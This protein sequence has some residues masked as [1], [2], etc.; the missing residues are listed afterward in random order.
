MKDTFTSENRR[1]FHQRYHGCFAWYIP[2]HGD[3]HLVR[4][5]Q[6]NDK[7]VN[8]ITEDG[9]AYTA[10]IDQGVTWEFTQLERGWYTS[11]DDQ[12]WYVFRIPQRQFARGISH[13]NTGLYKL[14]KHLKAMDISFSSVK[15]VCLDIKKDTND[16]VVLSKHF[17][18]N[19]KEVYMYDNIIGSRNKNVLTIH[20]EL[21]MQEI[22]D[23]VRRR[24]NKF[25]VSYVAK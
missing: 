19:Q 5:N 12:A 8:F 4:I 15:D 11:S 1:D 7:S 9:T 6:I 2:D 21:F 25:E 3:K 10:N 22:C 20:N 23:A 18:I 17:A 13:A 16:I 24:G 14:N